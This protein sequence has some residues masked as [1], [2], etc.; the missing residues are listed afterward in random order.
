MD[1]YNQIVLIGRLTRDPE[2]KT[3]KSEKVKVGFSLAVNRRFR[4]PDGQVETDFL[5]VTVWGRQAEIAM[6]L[7]RKGIRILVRGNLQIN[8]FEK[9]GQKRWFTE[10]NCENFQ[11]LDPKP[12]A[13]LSGDAVMDFEF[14][15]RELEPAMG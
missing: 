13:E 6:Q 5:N 4:S 15:E 12:K 8:T 2:K 10:I 14:D 11:L 7:L 3:M 9:D 1:S